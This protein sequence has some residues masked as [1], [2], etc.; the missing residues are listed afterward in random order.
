MSLPKPELGLVIRLRIWRSEHLRGQEEGIKDRSCA[1]VLA[2]ERV[3]D[4]A[5]GVV[6]PVTGTDPHGVQVTTP[7]GNKAVVA[8]L[9][10]NTGIAL[11]KFM[12]F[13][14]TGFSAMLA[15]SIHSLADCVNQ[16]L[17]LVG[18]HRS[19]RH[20]LDHSPEDSVFCS[21]SPFSDDTRNAWHD[22]VL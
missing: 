3:D 21:G 5:Y 13:L 12:A 9:L 18:G 11:T 15:E 22:V 1:I 6:L 4:D 17:L 2:P 20:A 10:A 16:V 19:R 7:C 8:A 14:L